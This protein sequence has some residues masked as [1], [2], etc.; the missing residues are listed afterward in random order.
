MS[1]F[2]VSDPWDLGVIP[3][4]ILH[5]IKHPG[6][7]SD[8]VHAGSSFAKRRVITALEC[9]IVEEIV[10]SSKA[11]LCDDVDCEA[12]VRTADYY[13]LSAIAMR[14]ESCT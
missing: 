6:K 10:A 3:W 9:L 13:R 2:A 7:V 5:Y 14:C 1:A 8:P 11:V 4:E 12:R